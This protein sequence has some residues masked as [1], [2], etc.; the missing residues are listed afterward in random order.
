MNAAK[1]DW[2]I[3]ETNNNIIGPYTRDE[4]LQKIRSNKI[5]GKTEICLANNY[6]FCIDEKS[7]LAKFFKEL[8]DLT[9][10]HEK[11]MTATM[12]RS[13]MP[14]QQQFEAMENA[15]SEQTSMIKGF[16][17]KEAENKTEESEW[18]SADYAEEFGSDL[19]VG[20][21]ENLANSAAANNV[22]ASTDSPDKN[23]NT[24]QAGMGI[25]K[26][27]NLPK[28]Q[29]NIS[30]KA[31][32][33]PKYIFSDDPTQP[34]IPA[35]EK[36][37]YQKYEENGAESK[38]GSKRTLFIAS[39]SIIGLVLLSGLIYF[40][41]RDKVKP[42]RIKAEIPL[43]I[44]AGSVLD[45]LKIGFLASSMEQS[46][47]A[48]RELEKTKR[49]D[50]VNII[51]AALLK[52][53]FQFDLDGAL[54]QLEAGKQS[55]T[56]DTKQ[57]AELENLL[58]IFSL[59][60]NPAGAFEHFK[61]ASALMPD[62][63]AFRYNAAVALYADG[64]SIQALAV[65]ADLSK[66]SGLP[67]ILSLL[68]AVSDEVKSASDEEL[69]KLYIRAQKVDQSGFLELCEGVHLLKKGSSSEAKA[70]FRK[71]L[72][73]VYDLESPENLPNY[74]IAKSSKIWDRFL[75]A[76]RSSQS[77]TKNANAKPDPVLLSVEA[78]LLIGKGDRVEAAKTLDQAL[79][80]APG[81]GDV[82]VAL[83]YLKYKE[84]KF[85]EVVDL[86]KDNL[87]EGAEYFPFLKLAG[88]SYIKLDKYSLAEK[89]LLQATRAYPSS[90]EVLAALGDVLKKNGDKVT[91]EEMF[92]SA[93]TKNPRDSKAFLGI[94]G[95][96]KLEILSNPP[97]K[98]LLP[99]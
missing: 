75:D 28:P 31:S 27:E 54:N 18:L 81:D 71:Y 36:P 66:K 25:P 93:L 26:V 30:T 43:S 35:P 87:R 86:L 38:F 46:Q 34:N 7:E 16:A 92:R 11:E 98:D 61:S 24:S 49:G 33:A 44:S 17:S 2:L 21:E 58:G 8:A 19:L 74:R 62:E 12:T 70:V 78:L 94:I 72:H 45:R 82:L 32:A 51:G 77:V 68:Y 14:T 47:L 84:Q 59:S 53:N 5:R 57:K 83:S 91:S 20:V 60:G 99:F 3:R 79:R 29:G 22:N 64:K 56:L 65:L 4:V 42:A 85:E 48:L 13:E 50:Y 90:P 6:W 37:T 80:L 55:L 69:E 67:E 63:A 15:S 40:L 88:F 76:I 1:K 9:K 89:T 73:R 10:E 23:S 52:A 95:Q 39:L 41:E 96:G 97:Y